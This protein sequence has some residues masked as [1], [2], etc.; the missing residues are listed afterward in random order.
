MRNWLIRVRERDAFGAS[1]LKEVLTR[2]AECEETL[3]TYA[4]RVYAEETGSG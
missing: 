4:A 3:E 1:G 2:L